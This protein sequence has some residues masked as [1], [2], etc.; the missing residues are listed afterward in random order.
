MRLLFINYEFPPV[1]GGAAYASLATARE[2][3]AMGHKVDFLT[4]TTQGST[5]DGQTDGISVH[6]VRSFR[7]GVHQ[8]GLF[9]AASLCA[10]REGS[11]LATSSSWEIRGQARA[12]SYDSF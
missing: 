10:F 1:G 5:V 12:L 7:R 3:V 11:S 4:T 8:S 2:L 9:G 6:R